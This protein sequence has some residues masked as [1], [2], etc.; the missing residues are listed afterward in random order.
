MSGRNAR[1]GFKRG[2]KRRDRRA[3]SLFLIALFFRDGDADV[4]PSQ[5]LCCESQ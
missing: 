4:F 2:K 1:L 3:F 5:N